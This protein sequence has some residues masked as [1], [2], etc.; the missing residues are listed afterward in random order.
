[1]IHVFGAKDHDSGVLADDERNCDE[2]DEG[3]TVTFH[4]RIERRENGSWACLDCGFSELEVV[5]GDFVV[6]PAREVI[7]RSLLKDHMETERVSRGH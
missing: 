1:M 3:A 5:N 7:G 2:D 6:R 4:Q